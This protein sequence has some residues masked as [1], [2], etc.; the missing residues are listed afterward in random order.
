MDLLAIGAESHAIP[1]SCWY[2]W[3]LPM[4]DLNGIFY[5]DSAT[6]IFVHQYSHAWFDSRDRRD[7]DANYFHNSQ[8]V[9]G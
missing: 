8:H 2:V 3:K 7:Q 5:I 4:R 1:A 6:P 9:T